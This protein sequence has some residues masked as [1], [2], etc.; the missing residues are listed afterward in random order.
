MRVR[1]RLHV[2]ARAAQRD[3]VIRRHDGRVD[4][5]SLLVRPEGDA[6]RAL[7]VVEKAGQVE[8]GLVLDEALRALHRGAARVRAL[9]RQRL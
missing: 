3:D 8:A 1:M 7:H 6:G 2:H 9:E 5:T 4:Q